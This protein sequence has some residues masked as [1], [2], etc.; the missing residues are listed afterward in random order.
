MGKLPS[1]FYYER[2]TT[3]FAVFAF[4]L[5]LCWIVAPPVDSFAPL[6][7]YLEPGIPVL[8]VIRGIGWSP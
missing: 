8:L 7:C 5:A 4:T 1:L 3:L 2:T 6:I